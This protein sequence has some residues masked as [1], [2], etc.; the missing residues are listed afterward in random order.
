MEDYLKKNM[1]FRERRRFKRHL[2]DNP[3]KFRFSKDEEFRPTH[4]ID[5]SEGGL[6]FTSAE[7]TTAGVDIDLEMPLH[8][9]DYNIKARVARVVFDEKIGQYRIGVEFTD[10]TESFRLDLKMKLVNV[11]VVTTFLSSMFFSHPKVNAEPIPEVPQEAP[12]KEPLNL[13][14]FANAYSEES[15][16]KLAENGSEYVSVCVTRF[17]DNH[18][19]T[20]IKETD[21]TPKDDEVVNVIKTAK[22]LGLKVV[23]KPRI[24]IIDNFDNTYTSA[25]IGFSSEEDWGKWFSEYTS[26]IEHYAEIAQ[27]LNV[28][29]LCVGTRLSFTTQ[30]DD[31]WSKVIADARSKYRGKLVYGAS[32]EN[33]RYVSFWGDLDFVGIEAATPNPDA[34]PS[35][36]DLAGMWDRWHH[37]I[38]ALQLTL[39]KPVILTN[40]II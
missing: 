13:Q 34:L 5:A 1:N 26:F 19:S 14:S 31:K 39:N 25:D 11:L 12:A 18:N 37:I 16:K 32:E 40:W 24:T 8:G 27:E 17:Q 38:D 9:K 3:L 33:F 28:E 35:I 7:D 22:D 20:E 2:L 23:L 10:Y 6:M 15:L 36:E 21:A 30:R 29:I 4:T